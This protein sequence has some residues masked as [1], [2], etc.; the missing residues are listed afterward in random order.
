VHPI[1]RISREFTDDC[2]LLQCVCSN[3]DNYREMSDV[4][5]Q[6]YLAPPRKEIVKVS[7]KRKSRCASDFYPTACCCTS[8]PLDNDLWR[9][10]GDPITSDIPTKR[11]PSTAAVMLTCE[12]ARKAA[13]RVAGMHSK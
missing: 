1:L 6:T 8:L 9:S 10:K 12:N 11:R 13:G 4:M 5:I 7:L 2:R 3:L